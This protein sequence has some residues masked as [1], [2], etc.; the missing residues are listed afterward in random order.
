MRPPLRRVDAPV[1]IFLSC[2]VHALI[3]DSSLLILCPIGSQWTRASMLLTLRN[4][5]SPITLPQRKSVLLQ[6]LWIV[7]NISHSIGKMRAIA[8]QGISVISLPNTPLPDPT[9]RNAFPPSNELRQ[10]K[11]WRKNHMH[12]VGH[13]HPNM[14]IHTHSLIIE[15]NFFELLTMCHLFKQTASR[16]LIQ[17]H[18]Q[19]S[20]ESTMI[21]RPRIFIPRLGVTSAPNIAL[22]SPIVQLGYRHGITQTKGHKLHHLPLL[23]VRKLLPVFKY[24]S[25]SIKELT[26]AENPNF[27][28]FDSKQ[29]RRVDAPVHI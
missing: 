2:V 12:M 27:S 19:P 15:K 25:F 11:H 13:N 6:A 14:M 8:N 28:T 29:I 26:H 17:P 7:P 9:S 23:P 21:F 5:Q 4:R 18:F 16:P 3:L 22:L 24:F 20:G 1:H 10:R